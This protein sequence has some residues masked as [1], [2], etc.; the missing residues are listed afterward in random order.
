MDSEQSFHA[1]LR[2][3]DARVNLLETL[4]GKPAMATVSSFS[5]GFFTG[6]PQTQDHSHLLGMRP[7]AQGVDRTQLMLHFR[8]T[9]NGYI[10]TLKNPG[11]HYNKL[12]S[13][14]LLEVLGA[15]SSNTVNP[16]RFILVDH[17][18]NIITRK[19]INTPHTPVSLMT[20]VNKYVGGL[21]VRGSPYIYLAETEE[22]SKI[23]FILSLREG[24]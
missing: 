4:H 23:T 22:K 12:I 8:P 7:E 9:P 2:M 3:F 21:R 24:M 5:G 11:E 10:L 17:Q 6:K 15:E 14:S 1:S 16:T 19:N 20:T 18:Q 13:R